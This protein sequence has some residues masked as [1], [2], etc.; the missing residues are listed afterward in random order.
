MILTAHSPIILTAV[1]QKRKEKRMSRTI[2]I[3]EETFEKIKEQLGEQDYKEIQSLKDMVG[4]KFYFRTVT[5]HL[6]G[7]VKRVV[8]NLLELENAAWIADSG[9]FMNAIKEGKLNEVE[10]VGRAYVNIDTVTDI[11]PWKHKL[12]ETQI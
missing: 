7:R 9:R 10:P 4:E 2:E 6:T 5:Y 12:P 11:F 1:N 8:G 3:S